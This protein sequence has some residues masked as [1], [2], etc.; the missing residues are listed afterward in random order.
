MRNKMNNIE[1]SDRLRISLLTK[2]LQLWI[3]FPVCFLWKNWSQYILK[4]TYTIYKSYSL[5][6]QDYL[7][8]NHSIKMKFMIFNKLL[9]QQIAKHANGI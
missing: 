3:K 6:F 4:P 8:R 1:F 7:L 5:Y 2:L 9:P